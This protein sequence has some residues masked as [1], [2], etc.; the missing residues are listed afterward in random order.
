MWIFTLFLHDTAFADC[1]FRERDYLDVRRNLRK[2]ARHSGPFEVRAAAPHCRDALR[3][4]LRN[5]PL[6]HASVQ[7]TSP[8]RLVMRGGPDVFTFDPMGDCSDVWFGDKKPYPHSLA[9]PEF[10]LVGIEFGE[11]LGVPMPKPSRFSY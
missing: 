11:R 7:K 3:A 2:I 4:V 10:E 5:A 8:C 9:R 6:L 1:T